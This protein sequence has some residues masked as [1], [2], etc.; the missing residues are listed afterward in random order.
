MKVALLDKRLPVRIRELNK[1]ED[2]RRLPDVQVLVW[3]HSERDLTPAHQYRISARTGGIVLGAFIKRELTGFVYSFPAVFDGKPVQHSHHLAVLPRFQGYGIGKALKWAQRDWAIRRGYSLVTW[4]FDPLQA[5][6]ANLNFHTLGGICRTYLPN[7]YG[8]GSALNLGPKIPTDRLLIEWPIRLQR[9]ERTRR[10]LRQS[11]EP[12]A[13]PKALEKRTAS[14]DAW[15]ASPRLKL[16]GKC[17]LVEVPSDI[18]AWSAD[19]KLDLIA[20]WQT[21]LRRTL[22]HYF[23][24]GYAVVDFLSGSRCFYVLEPWHSR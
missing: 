19:K 24:Q 17:L 23:S 8:M 18:K 14:P 10:G 6:N 21:N 12:T 15:P 3:G 2:C 20:A 7:F 1:I 11:Y 9:V 4:T 5:I 22:T 16:R 13:L